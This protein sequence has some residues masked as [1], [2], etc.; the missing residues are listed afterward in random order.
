MADVVQA[1][2]GIVVLFVV[3]WLAIFGGIG[4]LLARS[5]GGSPVSGLAW[6]AILGPIGWIAIVLTTRG[7]ARDDFAGESDLVPDEHPTGLGTGERY[8]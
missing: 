1:L 3:V 7:T 5:R 8:L 4:L 2:F 6:G